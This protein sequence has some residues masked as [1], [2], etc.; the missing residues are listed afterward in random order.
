MV[1]MVKFEDKFIAD[2]NK[3]AD[4]VLERAE[5]WDWGYAVLTMTKKPGATKRSRVWL[6]GAWIPE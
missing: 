2:E 1:P 4:Y 3:A 5:K 6:V